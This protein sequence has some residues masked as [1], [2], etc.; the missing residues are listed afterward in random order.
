MVRLVHFGTTSVTRALGPRSSTSASNR[1]DAC[2]SGL[3][4]LAKLVLAAPLAWCRLGQI[5]H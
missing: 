5:E 4:K 3:S 1:N 2:R